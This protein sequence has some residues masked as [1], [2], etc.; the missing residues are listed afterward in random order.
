MGKIAGRYKVKREGG[1][2]YTYDATWMRAGEGVIWSA[3]VKRDGEFAGAPNGQ[4][5]SLG[6][7]DLAIEIQRVI[8]AAI[9]NRAGVE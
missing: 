5:R 8:E 1:P 9:E 4:I 3:I 7:V 2:T 6:G